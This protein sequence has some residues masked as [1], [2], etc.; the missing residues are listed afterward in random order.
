MKER[1]GRGTIVS[2]LGSHDIRRANNIRNSRPPP[3]GE[4]FKRRGGRRTG[5]L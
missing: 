1:A 5:V 2:M 4:K 3:A